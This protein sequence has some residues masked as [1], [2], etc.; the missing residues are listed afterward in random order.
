MH[1]MAIMTSVVDAVLQHAQDN[2]ATQVR[3]VTLVVGE[4]R[5]VVD[6]LMESCFQHLARGTIAENAQLTMEK[7]PLRARCAE[8][9]LVFP[10]SLREPGAPSCPDCG[11]T[12]LGI[13]S[14]R[15]F[16]LKSIDIV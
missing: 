10:V 8:C 1:E 12:D 11:S 2:G 3:G 4:L 13:F 9:G 15:E 14:G 6:E 16:M 7:I 5:D